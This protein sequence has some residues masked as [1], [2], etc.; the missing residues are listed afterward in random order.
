MGPSWYHF[1]K[2]HFTNSFFR[3][4]KLPRCDSREVE[5]GDESSISSKGSFGSSFQQVHCYFTIVVKTTISDFQTIGTIS[6]LTIV[7]VF[8]FCIDSTDAK[9]WSIQE[10]LMYKYGKSMCPKGQIK[11]EVKKKQWDTHFNEYGRGVHILRTTDLSKLILQGVPDLLRREVW[12]IFS[13]KFA[14]LSHL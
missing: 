2:L 12:M 14:F 3:H 13:G 1:S 7:C 9:S 8:L 6:F 10:P 5:A 4:E 11:Q